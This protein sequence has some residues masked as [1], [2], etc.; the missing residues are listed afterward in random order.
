[1]VRLR[2]AEL[3]AQPLAAFTLHA[4]LAL[5]RLARLPGLLCR[6]PKRRVL[7]GQRRDSARASLGGGADGR[8]QSLFYV[9]MF[10][11]E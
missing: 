6:L 4:K 8:R 9:K 3:L 2:A 11:I 10:V 7:R 5:G 1:M